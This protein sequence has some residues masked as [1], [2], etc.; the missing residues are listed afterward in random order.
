M[1]SVYLNQPVESLNDVQGARQQP[2]M[3][4][5]WTRLCPYFIFFIFCT[6]LTLSSCSRAE[7]N[8][9][10][11]PGCQGFTLSFSGCPSRQEM[12]LRQSPT[13][14]VQ[15]SYYRIVEE[16]LFALFICVFIYFLSPVVEGIVWCRAVLVFAVR[17]QRGYSILHLLII[18]KLPNSAQCQETHPFPPC[19]HG[20]LSRGWQKDDGVRIYSG[21]T[22]WQ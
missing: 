22:M 10:S 9:A 4:A 5:D 11:S 1:T 19:L 2:T 15:L 21:I 12:S 18:C 14:P 3:M 6:A 13:P 16:Q 20:N 17:R 8:P 7:K